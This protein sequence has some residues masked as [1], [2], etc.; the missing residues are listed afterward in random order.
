MEA[1]K[2]TIEKLLSGGFLIYTIDKAGCLF[3]MRYMDY[4]K[5]EAMRLFRVD[6]K[7]HNNAQF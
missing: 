1:H 4:S 6:L 2:M 3:K 5:R 7:S